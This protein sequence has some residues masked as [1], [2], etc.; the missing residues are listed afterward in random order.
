MLPLRKHLAENQKKLLSA[1][2]GSSF[3]KVFFKISAGYNL[4]MP[5]DSGN[6]NLAQ[7]ASDCMNVPGARENGVQLRLGLAMGI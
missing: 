7:M 2:E 1:I 3:F 5:I 6:F 4:L